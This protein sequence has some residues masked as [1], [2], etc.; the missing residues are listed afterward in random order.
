MTMR[1][2]QQGFTL[3]EL[4]VVIVLGG[5]MAASLAVFFRPAFDAYRATR[6]RAELVDQA[7]TALRALVRDVRVAVPNSIRQPGTSCFELLPTS[8]G[9]RLRAGPDTVNDSAPDCSPGPACS[10]PLDPTRSSTQVDVLSEL[11]ATPQV[12]DWLVIG[13]QTPNDAYAG[14]HR[15]AITA[16]STPRGTDGRLRLSTA[17]TAVLAGYSGARFTVVPQSQRAVFYVCEG[18][19]GTLDASGNGKGTLARLSNYGF[20]A[21]Y[22]GS[23]PSIA[24]A[25]V[26]ATRVRSC[27]F[28]YDPSYGATQQNGYVWMELELAVAGESVPLVLGAQVSNVP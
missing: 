1:A 21:A 12:G 13:T 24:G 10:A 17:A 11:P 7:G 5:V 28:V 3:V 8:M 22:P 14:S 6:A 25:D 15:S 19:D 20:N 2:R 27:R 9:G 4:V 16:V 23:C 18:A 26:L